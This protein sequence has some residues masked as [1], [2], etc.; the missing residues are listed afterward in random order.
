MNILTAIW[1][2]FFPPD[3]IKWPELKAIRDSILNEPH[4]WREHRFSSSDI[5][6]EKLGVEIERAIAYRDLGMRI[7]YRG[8]KINCH[9]L[10]GA[11]YVW[12]AIDV[13]EAN[14]RATA[15]NRLLQTEHN[16]RVERIIAARKTMMLNADPT[17]IAEADAADPDATKSWKEYSNTYGNL[18]RTDNR[19]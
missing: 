7:K 5:V 18:F 15:K 8:Q 2:R 9:G 14:R 19:R 16:L 13:W 17:L 6:N 10:A 11:M 12:K 4:D 1:H 3:Y